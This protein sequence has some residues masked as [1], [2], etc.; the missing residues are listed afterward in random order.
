MMTFLELKSD[1]NYWIDVRV[2][3]S[4][5][6]SPLGLKDQNICVMDKWNYL[7]YKWA[8]KDYRTG[9]IELS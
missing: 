7:E 9:A 5:F 3:V 4:F 8:P 2:P 1:K 6:F